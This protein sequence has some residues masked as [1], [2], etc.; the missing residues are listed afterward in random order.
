MNSYTSQQVFPIHMQPKQ[1]MPIP[2]ENNN[3]SENFKPHE[4]EKSTLEEQNIEG[5]HT[6]LVSENSDIGSYTRNGLS[7]HTPQ[8][9]LLASELSSSLREVKF[10]E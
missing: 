9:W 8:D 4:D 3:A 10:S 1:N 5:D 7:G 6:N 2:R